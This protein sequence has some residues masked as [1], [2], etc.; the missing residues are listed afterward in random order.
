[1]PLL[2]HVL[3]YLALNKETPNTYPVSFFFF[4]IAAV[5]ILKISKEFKLK[6]FI[7]AWRKYAST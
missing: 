6:Y 5:M 7:F 3:V 2:D 1:M 4:T